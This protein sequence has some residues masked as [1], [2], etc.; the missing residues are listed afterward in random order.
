MRKTRGQ[1]AANVTV[2]LTA[3]GNCKDGPVVGHVRDVINYVQRMG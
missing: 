2:R 3:T 1:P